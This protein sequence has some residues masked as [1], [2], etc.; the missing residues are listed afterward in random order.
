MSLRDSVMKQPET[1]EVEAFG[2][3]VTV[4]EIGALDRIEYLE[5]LEKLRADGASDQ[6]AGLLLQ[7]FM[8]V[9]CS[10]EDGKRVFEDSEV[11][12]VA[13]TTT[14]L[15]SLSVVFAEA[16]KLNKLAGEEGN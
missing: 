8:L 14:D 13:A 7:V 6:R 16:T 11:E 2:K 9:K 1:V 15:K 5:Y 12:A 3:T 4:Q 10:V